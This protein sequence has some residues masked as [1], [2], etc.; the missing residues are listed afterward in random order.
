[1]RELT[2]VKQAMRTIPDFPAAGIL[3]KDVTPVLTRPALFRQVVE[4]LAEFARERGAEAIAG[5]EARGF[6]FGAAVAL[7]LGLPFVPV[8]KAGK[9]PGETAK[10]SYSLEYGTAEIEVHRDAFAPGTR[11]VVVDDLLAT[12]GTAK[13]TCS[14][15]ESIGGVVAGCAFIIELTFLPGRA[16]L[17]GYEVATFVRYAAGE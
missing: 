5:I 11:V 3:F 8:R 1:M 4:A 6:I 2:E 12:G 13:A 10:A 9:L 7:E 16:A 15:V 14:L 17:E